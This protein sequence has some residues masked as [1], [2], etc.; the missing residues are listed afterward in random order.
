MLKCFTNNLFGC[1]AILFLASFLQ[2]SIVTDLRPVPRVPAWGVAIRFESYATV[3]VVSWG[4]ERSARSAEDLCEKTSGPEPYFT[5]NPTL[6][7]GSNATMDFIV[8]DDGKVYSE[9]ITAST[10]DKSGTAATAAVKTWQ[11]HPATC[12]GVP[13]PAEGRVMFLHR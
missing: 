13:T 3:M 10:D 8:G 5:P 6:N 2:A 4:S 11:F 7:S 1:L 9:L 12:N